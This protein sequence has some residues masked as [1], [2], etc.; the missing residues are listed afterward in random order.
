M[1]YV[2]LMTMSYASINLVA[3]LVGECVMVQ[4]NGLSITLSIKIF[5]EVQDVLAA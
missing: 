5:Q 4:G 3:L 1:C 2:E